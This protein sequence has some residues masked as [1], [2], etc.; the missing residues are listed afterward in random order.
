MN[1]IQ[2]GAR[3]ALSAAHDSKDNVLEPS[4][5]VEST[6]PDRQL[7]R[8]NRYKSRKLICSLAPQSHDQVVVECA[9]ATSTP[10][11]AAAKPNTAVTGYT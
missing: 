4:Y 6:E 1:L 2:A 7:Y 3:A 8:H 9:N 11:K 5:Y 10:P